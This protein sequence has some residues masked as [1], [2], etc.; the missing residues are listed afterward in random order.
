MW[1][2]I[3][4]EYHQMWYPIQSIQLPPGS[5]GPC[6]LEVDSWRSV[7]HYTASSGR[8]EFSLKVSSYLTTERLYIPPKLLPK[9]NF[10]HNNLNNKNIWR[11]SGIYIIK[12]TLHVPVPTEVEDDIWL[13]TGT[14][15]KT[16]HQ[17]QIIFCIINSIV[18]K[19]S[20]EAS[21]ETKGLHRLSRFS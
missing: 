5:W 13:Q 12:I 6:G 20:I 11:T 14:Y 10:S 15:R 19:I 16:E 9:I 7:G 3:L 17:H 21:S 1:Q 2:L 8:I 18:P 4:Y